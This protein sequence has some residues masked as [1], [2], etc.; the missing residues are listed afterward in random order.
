[1]DQEMQRPVLVWDYRI[2][3]MISTSQVTQGSFV[4]PKRIGHSVP[5]RLIKIIRLYRGT[6]EPHPA[7]AVGH[8]ELAPVRLP[9]QD[10]GT[11]GK[12]RLTGAGVRKKNNLFRLKIVREPGME[13]PEGFGRQIRDFHRICT[14]VYKPFVSS[15]ATIAPQFSKRQ[16]KWSG[17]QELNLR[18]HV[19]KTCG[20]PLPYTRIVR[21]GLSTLSLCLALHADHLAQRVH[22]IHQ[23]AL[24]FHHCINGLVRH[25]CFVDDVRVL[26]ALDASRCL[27]VVV[28]REAALGFGTR[29]GPSSP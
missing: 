6:H 27:G 19:P 10:S 25:R 16:K 24:R 23:I 5:S 7:S 11:G 9:S 15:Y 17:W 22:H 29:H 14:C 3:E 28:Q 12:R 13:F 2:Q 4:R 1:M 8:G 18:G 26:A 21:E 20:W